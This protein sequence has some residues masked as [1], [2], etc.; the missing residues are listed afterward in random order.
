MKK[1]KVYILAGIVAS[2]GIGYYA[3]RRFFKKNQGIFTKNEPVETVDAPASVVSSFTNPIANI[4]SSIDA[5]VSSFKDYT[6]AT[7]STPLNVR[8]EPNTTSKI[9]SSIPKGT[10]VK[11]KASGTKDWFA[12]SKDGKNT[13]GF[14]S[15]K[16]LKAKF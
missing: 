10:V 12:V 9:V 7:E 15:A 14:V 16:F 1:D 8:Q 13:V 6:V 3:Y 4:G 11:A 2:I 5:F